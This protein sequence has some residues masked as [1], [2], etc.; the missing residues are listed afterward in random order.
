MAKNDKKP[1]P[2]F[3]AGIVFIAAG[4][5][6]ISANVSVGVVMIVIGGVLMGAS[7]AAA[8]KAVRSE[9]KAAG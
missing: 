7:M 1:D 5:P 8:K 2:R 9:D 3:I 4:V 6:M